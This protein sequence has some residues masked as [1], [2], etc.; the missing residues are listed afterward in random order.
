MNEQ[1]LEIIEIIKQDIQQKI[2]ELK[3]SLERD[4]YFLDNHLESICNYKKSQKQTKI[5]LEYYSKL[6]RD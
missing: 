4:Q 6:L 1:K 2:Q 5:L 3:D